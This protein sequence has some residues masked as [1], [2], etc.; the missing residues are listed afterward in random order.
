LKDGRAWLEC[1][2]YRPGDNM[3][4]RKQTYVRKVQAGRETFVVGSGIYLE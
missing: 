2:W 1:Y 3:P 4:V